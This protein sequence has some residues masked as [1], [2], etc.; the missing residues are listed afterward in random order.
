ML[1]TNY[2]LYYYRPCTPLQKDILALITYNLLLITNYYIY[3]I[4]ITNYIT[5]Y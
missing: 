1:I 4:L 5:N 3:Y 2:L